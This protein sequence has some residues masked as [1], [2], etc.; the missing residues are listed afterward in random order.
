MHITLSPQRRDD[1]LT[2]V[3]TGDVLTLNGVAFDLSVIPE[4]ATLPADAIDSEWFTGPVER[5]DGQLHLTLILPHGK[6]A[7]EAARFPE[8]IVVTTDGIVELPQ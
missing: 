7:S 5:I 8:P 2:L 4:G 6:D 1:T 3:K